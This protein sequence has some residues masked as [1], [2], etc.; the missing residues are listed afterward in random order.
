MLFKILSYLCLLLL[1]VVGYWA[2]VSQAVF[3]SKKL[4]RRKTASPGIR[5]FFFLFYLGALGFL[6]K[7]IYEK[8]PV[9]I[10]IWGCISLSQV[11]F[12]EK[13][14]K[15]WWGTYF[16]RKNQIGLLLV[17]SISV[18]GYVYSKEAYQQYK[19]NHAQLH[20]VIGYIIVT[21]TTEEIRDAHSLRKN[22]G[23]KTKQTHIVLDNGEKISLQDARNNPDDKCFFEIGDSVRVDNNVII[24]PI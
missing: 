9:L 6:L 18:A 10:V 11:L 4:I 17:A 24:F 23:V 7:G 3:W 13:R 20:K 19:W 5:F 14:W 21:E 22:I 16:S 8:D 1:L 15:L 12:W 2:F